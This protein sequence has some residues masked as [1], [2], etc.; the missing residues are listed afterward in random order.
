MRDGP[1][2]QALILSGSFGKGHD[3]VAEACAAAL[4]PLD[5]QSRIVDSI[6]LLGG[7]GSAVGD[8][9]FRRLLSSAP[10][11]DAFHFSQLRVGH[12]PGPRRRRPG[13]APDVPALPRRGR[14]R[15]RRTC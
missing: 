8:W 5:T 11:Y 7:P 10:I 2:K 15:G 6:A 9:V 14:R 1:L 3:I 4:E 13:P 12:A